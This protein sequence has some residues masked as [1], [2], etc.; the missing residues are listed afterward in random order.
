ARPVARHGR[1]ARDRA[2]Q[3]PGEE[4]GGTQ[5][6]GA[7]EFLSRYGGAMGERQPLW[8]VT[9]AGTVRTTESTE[10]GLA[11]RLGRAR[12]SAMSRRRSASNLPAAESPPSGVHRRKAWPCA[13]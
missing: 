13:F 8:F 12:S 3:T 11:Q 5:R 1:A 2:G 6:D 9:A 7:T 4:P 10:Q